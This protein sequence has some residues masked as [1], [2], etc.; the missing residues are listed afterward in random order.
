MWYLT[1][2]GG[3]SKTLARLTNS[4]TGQHWQHQAGPASLTNDFAQAIRNINLLSHTLCQQAGVNSQHVSAVLGLA[5]AGNPQQHR[6]ASQQLTPHFHQL[7]LTTDARTSLYGANL[8]QPVLVVALGTG[9]VAMRLLADGSEQQVGGWGFNIGD[10]GGGAWLGKL[11]VRQL[12]WQ[13]DS[14][15]GVSS[16]L[17]QAIA[18]RLGSDA[19]TLLPWLKKASPND[20][21][22]LVPLVFQHSAHCS[23]ATALL[24]QHAEAV[25]QLIYC[26]REQF[27]LPVMLLGGLADATLPLLSPQCRT[28]LQPAR[29]DALDGGYILAAQLTTH[30]VTAGI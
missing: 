24:Q 8:G 1:V 2:D 21:A 11:A 3:G 23:V 16:P 28:L 15:A 22:A 7:L 6:Q 5:G 9:S 17:L 27:D 14:L 26:A 29:G 30:T 10:E 19:E 13:I 12:L 4:S 25:Q 18:Q 20:F